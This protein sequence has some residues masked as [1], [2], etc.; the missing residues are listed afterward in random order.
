MGRGTRFISEDDYNERVGKDMKISGLKERALMIGNCMLPVSAETEHV[1]IIGKPGVGKSV[2]AYSIVEQLIDSG[3][4]AVVYDFKGDFL[5]KFYDEKHDLIF[6]P[7]DER[8]VKW[9]IIDEITG[10]GDRMKIS[11]AAKR[12][13]HSLIPESPDGGNEKFFR[14]GARA[15]LKGLFEYLINNSSRDESGNRGLLDLISSPADDLLSMVMSVS[16]IAANFISMPGSNQTAGVLAVLSQFTESLLCMNYP[17]GNFTVKNW[18]CDGKPG[19][20]YVT[21]F[22]DVRD[23]LRPVLSLLIDTIASSLLSLPDSLDRRLFFIL[24]EFAT[25]QRL[26]S[27]VELLTLSRSKGGSV[28][29]ATQDL[30]Q[31]ENLYGTLKNSIV[32]ACGTKVIFA[33][34]DPK[35]AGEFSDFISEAEYLLETVQDSGTPVRGGGISDTDGLSRN[36]NRTLVTKNVVLPSNIMNMPKFSFILRSYPYSFVKSGVR[37]PR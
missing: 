35:D 14:D 26:N 19:I 5:S 28:W 30:S 15:V 36:Y 24:D 29:L 9:N 25:L 21:G 32:N 7:L 34:A 31:V 12:I 16:P 6:N 22:A 27:L 37:P 13:C 8:S 33:V 2:L 3:R 10:A 4:K 17:D 18:I 11:A 20:L 1:F 23:T